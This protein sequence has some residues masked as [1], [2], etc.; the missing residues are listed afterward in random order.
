MDSG[1]RVG[2][3]WLGDKGEVSHAFH[4]L[5]AGKCDVV[6]ISIGDAYKASY[7]DGQLDLHNFSTCL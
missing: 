6:K 4:N 7:D 1:D 2:G 5:V 3:Y